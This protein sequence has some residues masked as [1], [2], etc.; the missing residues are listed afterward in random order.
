MGCLLDLQLPLFCSPKLKMD[1][2]FFSQNGQSICAIIQVR[3]VYRAA[4]PRGVMLIQVQLRG[5][6]PKKKPVFA[7]TTCIILGILRLS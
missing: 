4:N 2:T 6:K 7:S 3:S 5:V 1:C